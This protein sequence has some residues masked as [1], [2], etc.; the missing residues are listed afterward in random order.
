MRMASGHRV[1]TANN[2]AT[3]TAV[4]VA[5]LASMRS[6]A[7]CKYDQG[8][9]LRRSVVDLSARRGNSYEHGNKTN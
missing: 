3:V 7:T 9:L 1:A 8:R 6:H 2:M 4:V 5:G